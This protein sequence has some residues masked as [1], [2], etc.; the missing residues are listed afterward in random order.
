[1]ARSSRTVPRAARHTALS[2]VNPGPAAVLA[3]LLAVLTTLLGPSAHSSAHSPVLHVMALPSASAQVVS[4][5]QE[6]PSAASAQA[7]GGVFV[8]PTAASTQGCSELRRELT[9][10]PAKELGGRVAEPAAASAQPRTEPRTAPTPDAGPTVDAAPMHSAPL[11]DD[12]DSA[13]SSAATRGHRDTTG[14]RP[15]PLPLAEPARS[16]TAAG[17]P[18]QPAWT[19]PSAVRPPASPEAAGSPGVR[20]PPPPPGT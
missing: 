11:A 17:R 16:S 9:T 13:V 19:P 8:A 7:C 1:M 2:T 3:V 14:E 4:G 6:A 12:V 18:S 15:P 10:A 20:A 5:S